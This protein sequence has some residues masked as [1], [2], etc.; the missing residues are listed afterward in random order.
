MLLLNQAKTAKQILMKF[1]VK[2][3]LIAWINMQVQATIK[4]EKRG[5]NCEVQLVSEYISKYY[6]AVL[7]ISYAN[8]KLYNFTAETQ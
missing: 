4:L 1:G 6:E 8:D 7:Q 3:Q 2:L 5:W